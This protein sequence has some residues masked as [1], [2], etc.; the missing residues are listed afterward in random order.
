M[1]LKRIVRAASRRPKTTIALWLLFVVGC[2]V[3]GGIAG[4]RT[5]DAVRRRRRRVRRVAD[6]RI[7]AAGHAG[8]RRRAHPR[9]L[10]RSPSH[11]APR[12]R[13]L[14]E[15]LRALPEVATAEG[16]ADDAGLSD[17]PAGA[18]GLVV[19]TLRGDPEDAADH[20]APVERAVAQRRAP[21]TPA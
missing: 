14:T 21:G 2:V 10:R 6:K 16:P 12:P 18:R 17:A 19:V 15:R 11:A 5:L 9:P 7:D 13:A 20:V 8:A 3:A 4:T 1:E